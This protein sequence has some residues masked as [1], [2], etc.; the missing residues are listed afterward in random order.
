MAKPVK[1]ALKG[2]GIVEVSKKN[3]KE[4]LDAL[5][6]GED[7]IG[8]CIKTTGFNIFPIFRTQLKANDPAF[9]IDGGY[10]VEQ[11]G[12]SGKFKI[13]IDGVVSTESLKKKDIDAIAAGDARCTLESVGTRD[14]WYFDRSDDAEVTVISIAPVK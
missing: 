9:V 14:N 12:K 7:Y 1:F 3:E 13:Q 4:Y 8:V 2:E 11:I 10:K 5:A 6:S